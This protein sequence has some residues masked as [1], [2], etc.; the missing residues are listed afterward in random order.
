MRISEIRK[1]SFEVELLSA[2]IP[3]LFAAVETTN[4]IFDFCTHLNV[5]KDYIL[6]K[7]KD[8]QKPTEQSVQNCVKI[9]QPIIGNNGTINL[10]KGNN[11]LVVIHN[12]DAQQVAT[13]AKS[14]LAEIKASV[15]SSSKKT[16][17]KKTLFYWYQACFD[18]KKLNKSNLNLKFSLDMVF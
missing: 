14:V 8:T 18:E 17:Y 16:V 11:N 6:G 3:S 7:V 2:A 15:D 10:I 12:P 4:S 1:G 13:L 5:V 9:T